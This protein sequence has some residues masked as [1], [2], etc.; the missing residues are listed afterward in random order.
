[1]QL[2]KEKIMSL[3]DEIKQTI[4]EALM[5]D[6]NPQTIADDE[7]FRKQLGIDSVGFFEII[8]AIEDRFEIVIE[9]EGMHPIEVSRLWHEVNSVSKLADLVNVTRSAKGN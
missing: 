3:K 7:D 5:L 9:E 1:M 6:K 2:V 4:V 8:A